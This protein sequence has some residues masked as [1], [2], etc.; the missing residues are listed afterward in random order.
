MDGIQAAVLRV[1]LK[2]LDRGNAARRA[3][4]RRYKELLTGLD[5]VTLPLAAEY[6]LHAYH[7]YVV[8]VP[9]RDRIL[10]AMA[11]RGISCGIH[12]PKPVHLQDAYRSLGLGVGSFPVSERCAGESLSLPM[13]P[14]LTLQ[15]IET[16]ARELKAMV[17]LQNILEI[18]VA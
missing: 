17:A 6:G 12:Y 16:V 7:L 18:R 10:K 1:K 5:A 2:G 4:A 3:H 11:E 14:E 15:Q 8:R 13:F 9:E